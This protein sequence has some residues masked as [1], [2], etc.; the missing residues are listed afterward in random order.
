MMAGIIPPPLGTGAPLAYFLDTGNEMWVAK[1]GVSGGSWHKA[2]DV[3]KGNWGRSNVA[4]NI[5]AAGVTVPPDNMG[6]D[7]YGMW[8]PG[9]GNFY[10]LIPVPGVYRFH[11]NT[12]SSGSTAAG[13]QCTLSIKQN[14][15]IPSNAASGASTAA[16]Q[17]IGVQ[18][19]NIF[20]CAVGDQVSHP[21]SATATIPGLVAALGVTP[22]Y[23]TIEYVGTG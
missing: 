5:T 18:I 8:V 20:K 17:S 2:R 19:T 11:C 21:I 9:G 14:A 16:G 15:L 7:A 10:W 13:Q 22:T 1:G 12:G 4:W 6:F 23:A 3:L